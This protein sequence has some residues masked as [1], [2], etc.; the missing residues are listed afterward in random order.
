MFELRR[1]ERLLRDTTPSS[2]DRFVLGLAIFSALTL[3][4]TLAMLCTVVGVA[5]L[6]LFSNVQL[7][8]AL[9][10]NSSPQLI[11]PLVE[12]TPTPLVE[13]PLPEPKPTSEPV[14]EPVIPPS[15]ELPPPISEQP[16]PPPPESPLV[17]TPILPPEQPP[18]PPP[19]QPPVPVEP[20]PTPATEFLNTLATSLVNFNN[21]LNVLN[22][23]VRNPQLSDGN[24]QTQVRS[25]R[26][27][28]QQNYEAINN[29]R[30][31]M[32]AE[33]VDLH[34]RVFS[35]I[36]QCI[37]ITYTVDTAVANQDPGMIQRSTAELDNCMPGVQAL[38]NEISMLQSNTQP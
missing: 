32:P 31:S 30:S 24:W 16:V 14:V 13:S 2:V 38:V 18:P 34:T 4:G 7:Y 35:V 33:W 10:L 12:P 36:Q 22:G 27:M 29:L 19:E 17:P 9:A 25:Q 37:S 20:S 23:F 11:S 6:L 21:A 8:S 28:L 26:D 1:R 3:F 15:S 5:G